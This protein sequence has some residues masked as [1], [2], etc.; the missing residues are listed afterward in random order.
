MPDLTSKYNVRGY[1]DFRFSDFFGF[2]D[3]HSVNGPRR[4]INT[5]LRKVSMYMAR[6]TATS[7][8]ATSAGLAVTTRTSVGY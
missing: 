2:M 6:G 4:Y 5:A 3:H 1:S 8:S 7:G